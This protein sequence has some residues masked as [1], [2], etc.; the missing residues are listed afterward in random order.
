V[1]VAESQT[2][3]TMSFKDAV[4]TKP[5]SAHTYLANFVDGFCIG[6]VPH[7]GYVTSCFLEVAQLHFKS[8]LASQNQ[9]HT[10]ALHLDFLRRTHVGPA[11]FTVQDVKIGRQTS[12]IHVSLSQSL[13]S[14][15]EPPSEEAN[16]REEVV[17]YITNSNIST[18]TGMTLTTGFELDPPPP[19]VNLAHLG[20]GK[21]ELWARQDNM[22]FATFR[23]ATKKI[24][25]HFPVGGQVDQGIS[26]EWLRFSTGEKFTNASLGFVCDIFPTP[27]ET[28]LGEENPYDINTSKRQAASNDTAKFWYPTMLLNL[29]IKKALPE[30]GVE[31]LFVRTRPKEIKNG[32]MD[33]EIVIMDSEGGIVALSHHV[34]FVLGSERNT[35]KRSN[36][37]SM[38]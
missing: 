21:D 38:I 7:G 12:V 25:Y 3:V 28:L 10:I 4:T 19:T 11:L 37:K 14:N 17:G 20:Q 1:E 33:L 2:L 29:E 15:G 18:E 22:P 32:R 27:V 9:P 6:T 13:D 24:Q 26:D 35:A 34:C 16:V 5:L 23:K 30:D 36:P 8:T 31:W